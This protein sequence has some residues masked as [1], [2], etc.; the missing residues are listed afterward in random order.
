MAT[1]CRMQEER[2]SGSWLFSLDTRFVLR[3]SHKQKV[4]KTTPLLNLHVQVRCWWRPINNNPRRYD[5]RR[6]DKFPFLSW[7]RFIQPLQTPCD[8]FIDSSLFHCFCWTE[9]RMSFSPH[10]VN[11]WQ[12]SISNFNC[13]RRLVVVIIACNRNHDCTGEVLGNLRQ[14]VDGEIRWSEEGLWDRMLNV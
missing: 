8:P 13:F 14:V 6:H 1:C 3:R 9:F 5:F 2:D 7:H 4:G 12:K 11:I 10:L